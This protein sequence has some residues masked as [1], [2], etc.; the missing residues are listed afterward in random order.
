MPEQDRQ[1]NI[2]YSNQ[3]HPVEQ[4][5]GFNITINKKY[6]LI[7]LISFIIILGILILIYYWQSTRYKKTLEEQG[8]LIQPTQTQQPA[9]QPSQPQVKQ[10]A[11]PTTPSQPSQPAA[12]NQQNK[13]TQDLDQDGDGL[14]DSEEKQL[15]TDPNN[16]DSDGDGYKDGLEVNLNYSP[17]DKDDPRISKT[18]DT[19]N[20][21]LNNYAEVMI[22]HTDPENRD[23]DFD[24]FNDGDEVRA[25]YNPL[26]GG[27]L[28][29]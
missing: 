6:W 13:Q 18:A 24:G 12:N 11:T 29:K 7:G 25:G 16:P 10:P 23:S 28:E 4:E 20:D 19:D 21:K 22:Y 5:Q 2:N 14:T 8:L 15:G 1:N 17:L 3:E 26:G 9:S 27:K